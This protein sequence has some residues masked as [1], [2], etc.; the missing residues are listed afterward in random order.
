MFDHSNA[1]NKIFDRVHRTGEEVKN[2]LPNWV[3]RAVKND[4]WKQSINPATGNPFGSVG[5]WLVA[6]WPLGPGMGSSEFAITYDEFIVLCESRPALK[7]L[8]VA[9][10][11]K[12][13]HGGDRKSEDAIKCSNRT[14]DLPRGPKSGTTRAYL[15]D[16]LARD[17]PQHWAD[18]CDGKYRSARQAAIAAGFLRDTHNP[19]DRLLSNWKKASKKQRL[20]FVKHLNSNDKAQ[21]LK[22]IAG[23]I[24]GNTK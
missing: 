7:K 8:L 18:Y 3:E 17:F 4:T 2:D 11:P 24:G 22:W 13:K 15:E 23:T 20:E 9:S 5:E 6:S 19:I 10:R 16:R 14:L 12:R 21:V 1:T